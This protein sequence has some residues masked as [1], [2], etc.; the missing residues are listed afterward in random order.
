[1]A[2]HP[3]KYNTFAELQ[4]AINAYSKKCEGEI[5]KDNDGEPIFDRFGQPVIISQHPLLLLDLHLH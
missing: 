2:G 4:V 1:M 3:L 5:L